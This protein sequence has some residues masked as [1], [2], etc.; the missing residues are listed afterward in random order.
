MVGCVLAD[1]QVLEGLAGHQGGL[2][3]R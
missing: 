2:D 3:R 1:R